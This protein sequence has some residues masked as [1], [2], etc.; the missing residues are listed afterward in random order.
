MCT[1]ESIQFDNVY[2]VVL[3]LSDSWSNW[4]LKMLVFKERG[5]SE[6][7]KKSLWEQSREPATNSEPTHT[8]RRRQDLN[9]GHI[10]GR[11]RVLSPLRHPYPSLKMAI[12]L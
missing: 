12:D 3:G 8:W 9:S 5:K 2:S 1:F 4:N 7:P 10:G 11:R 6:Y